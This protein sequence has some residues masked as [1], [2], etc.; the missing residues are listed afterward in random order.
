M[1]ISEESEGLENVAVSIAV[2]SSDSCEV[3]TNP[4]FE[5]D[6]I[7]QVNAARNE[8]NG[9]L[10]EHSLLTQVARF[11][12]QEMACSNYFSHES[13]SLGSVELR[14]QAAGY[15]FVAIGENIASGYADPVEVVLA[16]LASSGH[17][18]NL[19]SLEYIHIGVGYAKLAEDD[20][21]A[22]WTI[23]LAAPE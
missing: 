15:E 12:S 18:E 20:Q 6:V 8:T 16:W 10:I 1:E 9:S 14:L 17:R 11:H 3:L 5:S 21:P 19:L 7:R 22:F 4:Q 23:V 2:G 13:P